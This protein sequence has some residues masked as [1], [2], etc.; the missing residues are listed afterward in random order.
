LETTLTVSKQVAQ[1]MLKVCRFV[2]AVVLLFVGVANAQPSASA[3]PLDWAKKKCADLGFKSGTERFGSCVLQLSR[4]DLMPTPAPSKAANPSSK[5]AV[6]SAVPALKTGSVFKDCPDCPDLVVIP[7]G[8]FT[9]GSND[10]PD[11]MPPYNVAIQSFAI[12]RTEVTQG[13]WKAVMGSNPSR[14][15]ECG[16]DCPV[17]RVSWDDIQGFIQK[18][19]A[20]TGK[21]YRL[22]SEAEWEYAAR[23]GGNGYWSFGNDEAQLGQYAWYHANSNSKTHTAA[24]KKPNAFGLF[25]MYGNVWEWTQDCRN[26]NYIGAPTEGDAWTAGDCG[27]RILRGG[28]WASGTSFTRAAVRSWFA[29]SVRFDSSGFRVA[30]SLIVK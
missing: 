14:F 25:D 6:T 19:N 5:K 13:Q 12:G 7:A 11:E 2:F 28:S 27:L 29:T 18:L 17:E 9:M 26:A 20:K 16:D 10:F 1:T 21:G 24:T 3:S 15:G 4:D 22:P 30:Q 8:S 23:A